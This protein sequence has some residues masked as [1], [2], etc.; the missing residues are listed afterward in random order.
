[1]REKDIVEVLKKDHMALISLLY[2]VINRVAKPQ[3]YELLF[4]KILAHIA[5]HTEVEEK[6]L[7]PKLLEID[8]LSHSARAAFADHYSI[9]HIIN[10]LK[11]IPYDDKDWLVTFK[12]FK[13]TL[14]HH[15]KEEEENIFSQLSTYFKEDDLFHMGK[16]AE[17]LLTRQDDYIAKLVEAI[18]L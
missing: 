1:M 12:I 4:E 18:S 15:M 10:E 9:E 17:E 13:A 16:I 2:E 11:C 8:E 14:I 3:T 5:K 7:Y 6:I